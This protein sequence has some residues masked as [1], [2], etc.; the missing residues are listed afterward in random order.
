M[1]IFFREIQMATGEWIHDY[2]NRSGGGNPVKRNKSV[3]NGQRLYVAAQGLQP[4]SSVDNKRNIKR[5]W[6]ISSKNPFCFYHVIKNR[7]KYSPE[8]IVFFLSSQVRFNCQN[9]SCTFSSCYLCTPIYIRL[10]L[11][12]TLYYSLWAFIKVFE[13]K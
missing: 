4:P 2:L 13:T 1:F 3:N 11:Y 5:S 6:T 10:F 12:Q 9:I 8:K 7:F